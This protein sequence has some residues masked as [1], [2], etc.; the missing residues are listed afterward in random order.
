M[1]KRGFKYY[2]LL[3]LIEVDTETGCW[4]WLGAQYKDGYGNVAKK[5]GD[6]KWRSGLVH[7][8]FY[9]LYHGPAGSL[10]VSH[11]CHRRLCIRPRHLKLK[12]HVQ[13]MR[14][15]FPDWEFG[16]TEREQVKALLHEG[17]DIS[18][19]ANK[20]MAPRPYIMRLAKTLNWREDAIFD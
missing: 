10:D 1:D 14:D 12:P 20:M 19:I 16:E 18:Y 5:N 2:Y 13:N 15:M 4:I 11:K 7:K 6:N 9:E 17:W 3:G 8:H